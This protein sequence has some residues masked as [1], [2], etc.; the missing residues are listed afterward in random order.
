MYLTSL[1]SLCSSQNHPYLHAIFS[2]CPLF[3]ITKIILNRLQ[4]GE[5]GSTVIC[6]SILAESVAHLFHQL[7]H[8]ERFK[9]L[10]FF[11]HLICAMFLAFG[12]TIYVFEHKLKKHSKKPSK[13]PKVSAYMTSFAFILSGFYLMLYESQK[14]DSNSFLYYMRI[15]YA[16]PL[17]VQLIA[18][19][20]RWKK[21]SKKS[22][23]KNTLI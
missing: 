14:D 12:N 7:A 9:S 23:C 5:L 3:M 22:F 15:A 21:T 19:M 2:C 10:Y 20:Y 4:R 17:T 6:L 11:E 16:L 18:A 13:S 1:S 8:D